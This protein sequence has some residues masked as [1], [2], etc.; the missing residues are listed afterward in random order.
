MRLP[1]SLIADLLPTDKL[2]IEAYY[3]PIIEKLNSQM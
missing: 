1:P 2:A 3:R